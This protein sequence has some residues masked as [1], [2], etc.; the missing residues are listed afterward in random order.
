MEESQ[1]ISKPLEN[2]LEEFISHGEYV[3]ELFSILIH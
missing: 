3:Y 2:Q 1:K